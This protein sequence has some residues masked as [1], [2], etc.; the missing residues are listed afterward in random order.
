[1]LL[2]ST[3]LCLIFLFQ[4]FNFH[5]YG[6]DRSFNELPKDTSFAKYLINKANIDYKIGNYQ[7]AKG[8]LSSAY[9]IINPSCSKILKKQKNKAKMTFFLT[10]ER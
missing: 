10:K 3:N 8:A 1:M 4:I 6:Q 7:D 2:K 5:L 9:L